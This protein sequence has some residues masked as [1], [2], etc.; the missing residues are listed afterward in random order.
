VLVDEP[1]DHG[2]GRSS[3]AAKKVAA[4]VKIALARS[5]SATLRSSS[6]SLTLSSLVAPATCPSSIFACRYQRRSDSSPTPHFG[7][8]ERIAAA[9]LG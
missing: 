1:A 3:S 2:C 4:A 6:A 8:I 9:S 5:S 7:A